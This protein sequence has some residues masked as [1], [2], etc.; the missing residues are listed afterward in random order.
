M[1]TWHRSSLIVALW[2]SDKESA[3]QTLSAAQVLEGSKTVTPKHGGKEDKTKVR[4]S[5][6]LRQLS[7][8]TELKSAVC[9]HVRFLLQMPSSWWW[10][11]GF[12][13]H[14]WFWLTLYSIA[15]LLMLQEHSLSLLLQPAVIEL[16]T[17]CCI[18]YPLYFSVVVLKRQW[19]MLYVFTMLL[20][21][22]IVACIFSPCPNPSP[23]VVRVLVRSILVKSVFFLINPP[24]VAWF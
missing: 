24:F 13:F 2:Q 1:I 4:V 16:R 6:K 20:T 18:F 17:I 3:D 19:H 10:R 7:V 21:N 9:C 8:M 11:I 23:D 5:V 14:C 12:F 15:S 22:D